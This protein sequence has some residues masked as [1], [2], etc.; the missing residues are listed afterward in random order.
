M[1]IRHQAS[2]HSGFGSLFPM[3]QILFVASRQ[4][5]SEINL[6]LI[7]DVNLIRFS[8]GLCNLVLVFFCFF[9]LC[10]SHFQIDS[11]SFDAYIA[12]LG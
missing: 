12:H 8:F 6:S 5:N 4:N 9:F 10:A 3:F 11:I 7:L 2:S 1:Y